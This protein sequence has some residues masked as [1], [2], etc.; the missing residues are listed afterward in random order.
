MNELSKDTQSV[1]EIIKNF[2]VETYD[3]FNSQLSQIAAKKNNLVRLKRLSE[4]LSLNLKHA[5][6][7]LEEKENILK[8]RSKKR[9]KTI[10]Q[11]FISSFN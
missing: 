3:A 10:L 4:D 9:K 11:V 7:E 6:L 5:S 2:E 8:G 1:E